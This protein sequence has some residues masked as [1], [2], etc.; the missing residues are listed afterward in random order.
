M[1][2]FSVRIKFKPTALTL[3]Y[4]AMRTGPLVHCLHGLPDSAFTY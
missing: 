4:L 3:H 1:N 2:G